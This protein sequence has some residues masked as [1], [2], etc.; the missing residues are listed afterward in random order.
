MERSACLMVKAVLHA[1]V[2]RDIVD[3][4]AK[5]P[6]HALRIHV[7]MAEIVCRL[8]MDIDAIVH[9]DILAST[10]NQVRKQFCL[11]MIGLFL[12]YIFFKNI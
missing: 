9:Q 5:S 1:S 11:I 3:Q 6:L 2:C 4:D 12:K 10:V 7:R 8:D